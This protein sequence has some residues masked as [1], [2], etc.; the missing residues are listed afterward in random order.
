MV[1]AS[2]RIV[3]GHL[4]AVYGLKGWLKVR[5][6]TEPPEQLFT[7]GP[8]LLNTAKGAETATVEH[9][10]RHNKGFIVKM[11]GV[12]DR[13]QAKPL[14]SVAI[15]IEK[16]QLAPLDAGQYYWHQLQGLRVISQYNSEETDL[17][18]V[19]ELFPTGA[20]DV[21]VVESDDRSI[22]QRQR[23][24]PYVVNQYV[25]MVDID[26]GAIY[27]EWDPDF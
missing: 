20:N 11:A 12:N 13:Q 17:G 7:Y 18:T 10:Q 5:S 14:C 1:S 22:D 8:W 25:K 19:K 15:T 26:G 2:D 6:Y 24:I 27:V 3:V 21:L 23:L 16:T 9:W 4:T